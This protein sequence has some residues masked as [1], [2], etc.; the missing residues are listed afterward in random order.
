MDKPNGQQVVELPVDKISR[1]PYQPREAFDDVKIT[2]LANS[3]RESGLLQ[4]IVVR[5]LD[6]EKGTYE[7]IAGE[8]RLLAHQRLGRATIPAIVRDVSDE[9]A[10]NLVLIENL[11]REDL[12]I[13]EEARCISALVAHNEGNRQLVAHKIG[14]SVLYVGGRVAFLTLPKDIQ[15][16]L[17]KGEI[18][19]AQA[20]VILELS[21][22]EAQKKAARLATKLNLNASQLRG[23]MQQHLKKGT[24]VGS[25]EGTVITFNQLSSCLVRLYD[26]L[27]GYDYSM[28]RDANKRETLR[29]QMELVG[30]VLAKGLELLA[31]PVSTGDGQDVEQPAAPAPE[32][33]SPART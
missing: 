6:P 2:E 11:Q 17:D 9:E 15:Q 32:T 16:M 24:G 27:D 31:L 10:R 26:A 14:K 3:I 12:T 5:V 28:L 29:K 33:V 4:P 21:G 13:I 7:L 25:G 19:I 20:N 22:E 1:S 23:R 8:R 18:N 30:K